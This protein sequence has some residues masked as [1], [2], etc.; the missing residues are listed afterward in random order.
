MK[1]Q[2][3]YALKIGKVYVVDNLETNEKNI[4]KIGHP[5]MDLIVHEYNMHLQLNKHNFNFIPKIYSD[6]T[7]ID[8]II[9]FGELY[10][11]DVVG[12]L[13]EYF[14]G[15]KAFDNNNKVPYNDLFNVIKTLYEHGF[16]HN[17]I[18]NSNV[19]IKGNSIKL[20]DYEY[21][22]YKHHENKQFL[23]TLCFVSDFINPLFETQVDF[24]KLDIMVNYR[25][26][27]ICKLI[28]I[29][30]FLFSLVCSD[31]NH[32]SI[33][34]TTNTNYQMIVVNYFTSSFTYDVLKKQEKKYTLDN[35]M[36]ISGSLNKFICAFDFLADD[37]THMEQLKLIECLCKIKYKKLENYEPVF[38][39]TID[40]MVSCYENEKIDFK[41][42]LCTF[43]DFLDD[44]LIL[45]YFNNYIFLNFFEK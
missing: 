14:D 35:T 19:L 42:I 29:D 22:L 28:N 23:N 44:L 12:Y 26:R 36:K 41:K 38:Y 33:F 16:V 32:N 3:L 17:D 39:N 24:L 25:P 18:N 6:L 10:E 37:F 7:A 13:M 4:L 1:F 15:Y 20:I 5:T 34:K 45:I 11:H 31:L 2:I 27:N 8:P 40:A 30:E 43:G 9:I 21:A